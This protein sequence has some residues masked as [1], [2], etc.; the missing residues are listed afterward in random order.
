[1]DSCLSTFEFAAPSGDTLPW[2]LDKS[3]QHSVGPENETPEQSDP[4]PPA[5]L[6][7]LGSALEGQTIQGISTHSTALLG[8]FTA[9]V[10]RLP[11]LLPLG[12]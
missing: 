7:R 8:D 2:P 3:A 5:D 1:M 10:N 6:R 12:L 11:A 4:R 9:C